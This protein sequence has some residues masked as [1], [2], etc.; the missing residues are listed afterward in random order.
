MNRY[1]QEPFELLTWKYLPKLVEI[2]RSYRDRFSIRVCI[3]DV[4]F[5]F[6]VVFFS[7]HQSQTSILPFTSYWYISSNNS[8]FFCDLPSQLTLSSTSLTAFFCINKTTIWTNVHMQNATIKYHKKVQ[9]SCVS[10]CSNI[11]TFF[12]NWTYVLIQHFARWT[13]PWTMVNTQICL[14]IYI[15]PI[16]YT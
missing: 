2:P 9:I 16:I 3:N 8:L 15:K 13:K 12:N 6:P 11:Y 10:V 5:C 4:S 1:S 7:K 14:N